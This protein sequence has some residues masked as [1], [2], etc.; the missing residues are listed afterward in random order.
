MIER[1]STIQLRR[2]GTKVNRMF[3]PLVH[4]LLPAKDKDT[5]VRLFELIKQVRQTGRPVLLYPDSRM[6][7]VVR[8]MATDDRLLPILGY[9]EK[10]WIGKLR[11][12]APIEPHVIVIAAIYGS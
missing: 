12:S 8:P 6:G 5:Y 1:Q 9:M 3:Q 4:A 2:G 10:V 11:W 7:D